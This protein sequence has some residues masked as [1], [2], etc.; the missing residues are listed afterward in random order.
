M[1]Q[2]HRKPPNS[3]PPARTQMRAMSPA[4]RAAGAD[5][6]APRLTHATHATH[7]TR[8]AH[9]MRDTRDPLRLAD[10]VATGGG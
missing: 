5:V 2:L 3:Q 1:T 9:A 6:P 7:V 10:F 8:V 4:K